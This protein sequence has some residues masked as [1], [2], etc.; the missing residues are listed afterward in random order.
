MPNATA[1]EGS[2]ETS[3]GGED[4]AIRARMREL[5]RRLLRDGQIDTE[6]VR[7]VMQ[8]VTRGGASET[9][10]TAEQVRAEL[11]REARRLDAALA[12]SAAATHRALQLIAERGNDVT[13]NDIKG[14]L[15]D[16][17]KLQKDCLATSTYLAAAARGNLRRELDQLVVQA[18]NVGAESSAQLAATI[19]EF[20]SGLSTLYRETAAP[21]LETAR[22]FS[23]RMALLTSGIIAGVADALSEQ[24][25]PTKPK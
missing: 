21:G 3:T 15:V 10:S 7:D 14:A 12:A 1:P 2:A 6:G 23:V 4:Q 19:N 5:T 18:Q 25:G 8:A 17:T 16:L 11:P 22:G 9:A 13:D 24:R 20:T